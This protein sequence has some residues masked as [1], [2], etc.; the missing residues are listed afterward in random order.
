[1][2]ADV[3][4][5]TSLISPSEKIFQRQVTK[6]GLSSS[7]YIFVFERHSADPFLQRSLALS[8]TRP[9]ATHSLRKM[10]VVLSTLGTGFD[11]RST[12]LR[13]I[14]RIDINTG[15]NTHDLIGCRCS[16]QCPTLESYVSKAA[17]KRGEPLPTGFRSASSV[18]IE[19]IMGDEEVL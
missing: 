12:Q 8:R 7:Q 15:C 19:E 18:N 4:L 6:L 10:C 1:V 5:D 16:S 9:R 17:P 2:I 3:F 13:D 14:F 11:R